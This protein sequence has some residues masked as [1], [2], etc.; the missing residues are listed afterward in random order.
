M[1]ELL[2]NKYT[3]KVINF[4]GA[5]VRCLI[6]TNQNGKTVQ[7]WI[8]LR[9]VKDAIGTATQISQFAQTIYRYVS[10]EQAEIRTIRA[11]Y[12]LFPGIPDMACNQHVKFSTME[13]VFKV[14]EKTRANSQAAKE[15]TILINQSF[16]AETPAAA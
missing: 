11:T 6:E 3:G 1:Y 14:L 16:P 10:G 4:Q 15:L 8:C 12:S 13:G 7:V 5:R 2:A 9:D